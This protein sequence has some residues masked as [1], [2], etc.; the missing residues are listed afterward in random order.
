MKR[1]IK[2]AGAFF[3]GHEM[4]SF[5]KLCSCYSVKL[6]DEKTTLF[7]AAYKLEDILKTTKDQIESW[8]KHESN[9]QKEIKKHKAN[10]Q[11]TKEIFENLVDSVLSEYN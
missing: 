1:A 6:P 2:P 8:K 7:E 4:D 10:E 9:A 11:K 3:S 5:K